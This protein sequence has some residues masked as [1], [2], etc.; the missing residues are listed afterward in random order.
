MVLRTL[1]RVMYGTGLPPGTREQALAS[2]RRAAELRPSRLIHHAEAGRV[3]LELG[4]KEEA[5]TALE[6]RPVVTG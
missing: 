6:V 1:V 5:R 4:R 2:Y 3:L